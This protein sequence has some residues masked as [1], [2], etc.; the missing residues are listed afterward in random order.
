MLEKKLTASH[1]DLREQELKMKHQV[2]ERAVTH[3]H[4]CIHRCMLL[5]QSFFNCTLIS[6]HLTD[7]MVF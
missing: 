5:K 4:C 7:E 2:S 3:T 6:A 1:V